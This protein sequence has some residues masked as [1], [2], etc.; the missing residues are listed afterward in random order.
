M[1]H[2]FCSLLFLFSITAHAQVGIGTAS[3]HSSAQL[4]VNSTLRGF[5]APRMTQQQ[6][7]DI[8]SPAT[9]LLVYQTDVAPGFYYYDGAAWKSGLGI[10]ATAATNYVTKFTGTNTMCNSIIYDDGTNVGISTPTPAQKLDVVGNVQFSGALMP[11]ALPGTSGQ[12]LTSSG[13]S[14]APTWTSPTNALFNNIYVAY[15]TAA[16]ATTTT[17]Q[18]IPGM[19]M[20]ITVPAGRTAKILVHAEVGLNTNCATNGGI[21][22]TDIAIY[23]NAALLPNG[24]LRRVY[25]ADAL[26]DL[27]DNNF[28]GSPSMEV[29]ETLGAGTYIYDLRCW[30]QL[31]GS[32]NASVGGAANDHRQGVLSAIVILQ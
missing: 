25:L 20:S 29:I 23:R 17:W 3:P 27:D 9:G 15:G 11:G 18:I 7:A 31:T 2:I 22:G 26:I 1:R 21:S 13:A 28:Y 14:T 24:G 12:V 19:T 16:V 30:Q 8:V 4:E 6:V 10:C 32:C 5:L